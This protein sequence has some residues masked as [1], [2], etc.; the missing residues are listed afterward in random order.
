MAWR[1]LSAAETPFSSTL[2][3]ADAGTM[4]SLQRLTHARQRRRGS[5]R[6]YNIWKQVPRTH[7]TSK[8][9][10]SSYVE[11]LR[12]QIP[13]LLQF[14]SKADVEV[15]RTSVHEGKI[16]RIVLFMSVYTT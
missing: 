8:V 4:S 9:D 10:G 6:S 5:T 1:V 3:V 16:E 11:L 15:Q 12:V 13:H 14:F 7:G 2:M